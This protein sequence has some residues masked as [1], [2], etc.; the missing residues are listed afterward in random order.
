M[1]DLAQLTEFFGW[2][3][4]INSCVLAFATLAL[5][6]AR[7]FIVPIHTKILGIDEAQLLQLYASYLSNYKI[8]VLLFS[9]TPYIALKIMG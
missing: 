7:P 5:A 9:F 1:T 6:V 4:V 3:L 8:A 2:T